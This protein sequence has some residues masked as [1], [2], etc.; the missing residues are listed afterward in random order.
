MLLTDAPAELSTTEAGSLLL[1]TGLKRFFFDTFSNTQGT[2]L[3]ITE[4]WPL[5]LPPPWHPE[6]FL[7]SL[8]LIV[9]QQLSLSSQTCC[10][11]QG[12]YHR[13]L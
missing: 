7:L 5:K 4:V 1:R 2:F 9:K 11:T 13:H 6:G 12:L 8:R 3:R 10:C